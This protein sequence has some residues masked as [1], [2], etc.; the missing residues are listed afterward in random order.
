MLS[1]FKWLQL[2]HRYKASFGW[3]NVGSFERG[4]EG[5]NKCSILPDLIL[6]LVDAEYIGN[7]LF[8]PRSHP[9]L[10]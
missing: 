4:S 1:L 3:Q 8:G 9:I 5:E 10:H 7:D 6:V 2:S